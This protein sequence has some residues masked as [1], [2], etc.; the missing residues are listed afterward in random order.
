MKK[1]TD[2]FK[3]DLKDAAGTRGA[4]STFAR[5]LPE[6]LITGVGDIAGGEIA[7]T[8]ATGGNPVAGKSIAY[9]WDKLQLATVKQGKVAT[10]FGRDVTF[11]N[12]GS[13]FIFYQ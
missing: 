3:P 1:T 9:M 4:V 10:Y 6:T 8:L 2:W 5:N 13:S 7:A 12:T 11:R